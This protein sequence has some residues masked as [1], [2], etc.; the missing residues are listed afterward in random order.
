MVVFRP[1]KN[2]GSKQLLVENSDLGCFAQT[3]IE[4]TGQISDNGL[5]MFNMYIDE[6]TVVEYHPGPRL[7]HTGVRLVE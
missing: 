4:F 3:E 6:L 1:L 2:V 5:R 7:W